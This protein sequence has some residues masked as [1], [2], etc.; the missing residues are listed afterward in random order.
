MRRHVDRMAKF[1]AWVDPEAIKLRREQHE[2]AAAAALI[3]VHDRVLLPVPDPLPPEMRGQSA[4]TIQ[5]MLRNGWKP[6]KL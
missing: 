2:K 3:K 5:A 6:E 4:S 1:K